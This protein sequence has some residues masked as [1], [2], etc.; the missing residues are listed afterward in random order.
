VPQNIGGACSGPCYTLPSDKFGK[1][2]VKESTNAGSGGVEMQLK[3]KGVDCP[4]IDVGGDPGKCNDTNHVLELNTDFGGL[5][6]TVGVLYDLDGGKS[7]FQASGGKNKVTGAEV[8]GSLVGFVQGQFLGI[9]ILRTRGPGGNP[10]DCLVAPLVGMQECNDGERYGISGILASDAPGT[11]PPPCVDDDDCSL[12]Q[13]CSGGN[14]IAEP[15]TQDSDC[16]EFAGGEV[17]C[18]ETTMTCC[19]HNLDTDPNCDV[20]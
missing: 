12:T 17:A 1:F 18:N 15:C 3:L 11:A 19:L 8:F 2:A 7:G 20:D 6:T 13:D 10:A 4:A 5:Q 14:C 16:D 9:G